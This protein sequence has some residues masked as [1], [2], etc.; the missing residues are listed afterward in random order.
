MVSRPVVRDSSVLKSMIW[1]TASVWISARFQIHPARQIHRI[2]QPITH[3]QPS[4][5][6]QLADLLLLHPLVN[7]EL[8]VA[9]AILAL[10]PIW[11]I[12]FATLTRRNAKDHV[13]RFGYQ[14]VIF[15]QLVFP[16]GRKGVLLMTT[17]ACG[18]T[19]LLTDHVL[20]MEPGSPQLASQIRLR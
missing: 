11:V 6:L 13:A 18:V 14:M 20:T 5:P 19:V 9:L 4:Q 12:H 7:P 15:R 3:L 8:D 1:E 2:L 10:A 16:F 17:A